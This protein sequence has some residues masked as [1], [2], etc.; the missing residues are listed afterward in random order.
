[1]TASE[2]PIG[3]LTVHQGVLSVDTHL[4][5][6]YDLIITTVSWESRGLTPFPQLVGRSSNIVL[7]RFASTDP[8]VIKAKDDT[9]N[10]MAAQL[11]GGFR[12]L[13]LQSSVDWDANLPILDR[14]LGEE[15][16]KL[17]RPLRM[18][19][20]MTCLP[21]R[22]LLFLLGKA[23]REELASSLEFVYAEADVYKTMPGAPE[24]GRY[25]SE[26]EW[27]SVQMPYFEPTEYAPTRSDL[28]IS[29][30]A[31]IT[32]AMPYVERF[33]PDELRLYTALETP[34]RLPMFEHG[35]EHPMKVHLENSPNSYKMGFHL[36]D[37][38]GIA[39]DIL[40]AQKRPTTCYAIG[41]KTH[42]LA[43]GIAALANDEIT[44]VCRLPGRYLANDVTAS[45]RVFHYRIEDRFD[46]RSYW[47][48]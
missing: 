18:L 46:P 34:V 10:T 19:V 23:F 37:A 4:E 9:H 28:F 31:E 45:G 8:A 43:L 27:K 35:P 6:Q 13:Q 38:I 12:I 40:R 1:M 7:L 15:A 41:P 29:L 16:A 25:V 22:Y 44:V 20:D 11:S 48:S 26:G 47:T 2:A 17:G 32:N 30:G 3:A 14:M 24:T 36:M 42:A 5:D 33:E 21:K 39:Q